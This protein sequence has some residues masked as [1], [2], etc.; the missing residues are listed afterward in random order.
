MG[1]RRFEDKAPQLGKRV[2]VD[3]DAT[4]I[5]EV[6]L[7]DD[8]SVW[9]K[10]VIRG[11]MHA[12]R[13]GNRVSIQDN[14]VLH[15]THDSPF[16]P[17]GFGLQVGDDVTLAHQA[18]LHGCTL[19]NRVMVGM[20]AIIMDGAIVEDDVIVAAGSLVGPGKHL[21]SGH[22]YRGQ[23]ARKIRPLT[24]KEKAFLPYVAGNYV[25]LKDRYLKSSQ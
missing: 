5:G 3:E 22:L 14:A 7:G 12:I 1:I 16:N 4:V 18:M 23:P 6:I 10:A 11:D 15:I 19:G 9:P 2:F 8:C 17:G 25:R 21:E 13:I 24:E 20:Q